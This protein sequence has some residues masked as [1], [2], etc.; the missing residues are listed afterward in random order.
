MLVKE[1][2]G[3]LI[4]TSLSQLYS[5]PF[6]E[7]QIKEDIKA[8]RHWPFIGEFTGDGPVMRKMFQFD[9]IIM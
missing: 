5:Q 9:D 8:P 6:V 2:P 1:G 4:A 3:H 7:A